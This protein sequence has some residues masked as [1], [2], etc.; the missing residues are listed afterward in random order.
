MSCRAHFLRSSFTC[1]GSSTG[2]VWVPRASTALRRFDPITAPE[3]GARRRAVVVVH[4]AGEQRHLLSGRPDAGHGGIVTVLRPQRLLGLEA[5]LA[6]HVRGVVERDLAIVDEDGGRPAGD[7]GEED[8]VD[9]E[10]RR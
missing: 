1:A 10:K 4:D 9:P 3:T 7:S 5:I 6:P 8:R 2:T